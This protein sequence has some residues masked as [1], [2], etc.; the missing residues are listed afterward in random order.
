MCVG[1]PG[2]SRPIRHR[3][4]GARKVDQQAGRLAA[5]LPAHGA[6]FGHGEAQGK[7]VAHH[8]ARSQPGAGAGIGAAAIAV[9]REQGGVFAHGEGGGQRQVEPDRARRVGLGREGDRQPFARRGGAGDHREQ[10]PDG[11]FQFAGRHGHR[12]AA[13][14]SLPAQAHLARADHRIELDDQAGE[15]RGQIGR[16]AVIGIART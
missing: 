5:H 1:P 8:A 4:R 11:V 3:W 10:A 13:C 15:Q 2:C 9:E 14:R 7:A 12:G 16:Q 6:H